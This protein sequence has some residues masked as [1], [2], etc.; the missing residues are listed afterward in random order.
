MRTTEEILEAA[1]SGG[2]WPTHDVDKRRARRATAAARAAKGMDNGR[3]ITKP[4]R[5]V[6][7]RAPQ[8]GAYVKPER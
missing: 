8:M 6:T 5:R 2:E 1:K 4:S 3:P 7:D